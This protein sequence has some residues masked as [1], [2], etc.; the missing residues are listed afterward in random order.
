[1]QEPL[2]VAMDTAGV[3]RVT[4]NRPKRANAF[5]PALTDALMDALERLAGDPKLR[6]LVLL[7]NGRTFCA[8]VDIKGMKDTGAA[9]FEA[10]RDDARKIARLLWRLNTMPVPT[11]A[12]VLGAAVGLGVGLV[13]C[14]DIVLASEVATFRFS[15]VRLGIIPSVISPYVVAAMGAR[16]CRRYFLTGETFHAAEAYRLGLVH[17]VASPDQIDST[18]AELVA[19]LHAGRK[20]ALRAAKALLEDIR[21][22]P[23]DEALIEETAR[24]LAEI[25]STPEA[26]Q[27]LSEF[28]SR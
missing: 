25:R 8:G 28:L 7:G 13:A 16:A 12:V 4:L 1:M 11:V 5:D 10:N 21:Q 2:D 20:G 3:A 22:R 27:A 15:E 19:A 14:C 6:A 18:A 23:L 9:T 26:Q 24:R 17:Q